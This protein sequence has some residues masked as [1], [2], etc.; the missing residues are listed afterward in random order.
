METIQ[1]Y[2]YIAAF[3]AGVF[4]ANA[5]PHFINGI[6]GNRFPTPFSRPPGKGLSSP[7]V[8]ILWANLNLVIGYILLRAGEVSPDN[9]LLILAF[10]IG[11]LAISIMLSINFS[12]KAKE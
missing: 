7:L 5:I 2:H 10:F 3:F 4:L 9:K 1:W 8:N 11:V 12:K 6:S